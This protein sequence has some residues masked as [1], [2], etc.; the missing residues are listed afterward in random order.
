[1]R[2]R[3]FITFLGGGAAWPLAARAQQ[4]AMPVI[5]Y[6]SA[7]SLDRYTSPLVA[8]FHHGLTESGFIEGRNVAI[9]YRWAEGHYDRLPALATE[10]VNLRVA[11]LFAGALPAALAA[12]QVTSTIPV[13]FVMGAD[14]V[15][16]GVVA[17]LNRP[18]GNLTGICS[19]TAR[20]AVSAWRSF[21][22]WS[23]HLRCS[24]SSAIPRTR[25]PTTISMRSRRLRTQSGNRSM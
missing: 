12:K 7:T 1:M 9:E 5:G 22:S 18:G 11:V 10:L 14:P 20:S 24:R 4:P 3:E 15:K 2:R 17:S 23:R 6:L 13:V 19:F 25:M 16:L 8:A 21:A